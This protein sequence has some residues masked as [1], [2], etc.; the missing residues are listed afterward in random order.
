MV[1]TCSRVSRAMMELGQVAL[2]AYLRPGRDAIGLLSARHSIAAIVQ[3]AV[4]PI[5]LH[6]D[7]RNIDL[8]AYCCSRTI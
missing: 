5:L 8:P 7:A 1:V 4:R 6:R 3:Q 2:S